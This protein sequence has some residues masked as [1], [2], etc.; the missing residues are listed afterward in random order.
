MIILLKLRNLALF[1]LLVLSLSFIYIGYTGFG[2]NGQVAEEFT[3]KDLPL[4]EEIVV[5]EEEDKMMLEPET[6]EPVFTLA[7]EEKIET[8]KEID[9]Y[10]VNFRM[11]RERKNASQIEILKETVN[12]PNSSP[13]MIKK[14]QE[15]LLKISE[16]LSLEMQAEN[17]LKAKGYEETAVIIQGDKT[18]VVINK[19][20][21]DEKDIARIGDLM[22][23]STGCNIEGVAII[24][25]TGG[26]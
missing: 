22:V 10:F 2:D 21:L 26:K 6:V 23:R 8:I 9:N 15:E 25:L 16:K 20:D 7:D 4:V 14:A 5:E 12:N 13:E 17:L 18:T 19:S 3:E 1:A 24:P 11:E